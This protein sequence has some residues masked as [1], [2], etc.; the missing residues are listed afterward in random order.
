MTLIKKQI[1]EICN[2]WCVFPSYMTLLSIWSTVKCCHIANW[3]K[4]PP[5]LCEVNTQF[6]MCLVLGGWATGWWMLGN[7]IKYWTKQYLLMLPVKGPLNL[8]GAS[9][10]R[11]CCPAQWEVWKNCSDF[12]LKFSRLPDAKREQTAGYV[13]AEVLFRP[14]V[15]MY[16]P[17]SSF[18]KCEKC[19]VCESFI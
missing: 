10:V 12:P 13:L 14:W 8:Q 17:V 15:T 2:N 6:Y 18:K 5:S 1:L 3:L 19:D 7:T 9:L 11:A 16:L 4:L